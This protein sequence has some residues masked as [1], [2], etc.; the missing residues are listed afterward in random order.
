[1]ESM[2]LRGFKPK[3]II[4]FFNVTLILIL[5]THIFVLFLSLSIKSEVK[6]LFKVSSRYSSGN[7]GVLHSGADL[8]VLR[9]TISL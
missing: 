5:R 3:P 1:M 9:A 7:A 6:A 2:Q 4:K 8:C